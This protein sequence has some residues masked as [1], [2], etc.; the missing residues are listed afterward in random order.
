MLVLQNKGSSI[1]REGAGEARVRHVRLDHQV[2]WDRM[3]TG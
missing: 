2:I 3:L 1:V